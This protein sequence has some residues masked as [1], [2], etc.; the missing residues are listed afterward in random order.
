MRR[1]S[2]EA[3]V[4]IAVVSWN[5]RRLL[6]RCLVSM[7]PDAE[8]G[9]ADVWVV[10]NGSTD[11]SAEMVEESFQWVTLVRAPE[12][13]GYGR[14]VNLV[15]ERTSSA[16]VAPANA[17]IELQPGSLERLLETGEAT[18]RAG[19]IA[20]RLILPDGSTQASVQP[21]PSIRASLRAA[22]RGGSATARASA[23]AERTGRASRVD[24]ATGAFVLVPRA[25]W[26]AVG[27][28]DARQW[29]Y[30]EDLDLAWRL[31]RAGCA[32]WY[33][34]EARVVH[35]L[36]VA[37]ARAFGDEDSRAIRWMAANYRWLGRRRGAL[38]PVA[39]GAVQLA[40]GTLRFARGSLGAAIG[41]PGARDRRERARRGLARQVR[42]Q[43][44]A[45]TEERSG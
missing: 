26:E 17:D 1:D 22:G 12:N 41:R 24:W 20:P 33:D 10:D 35:H 16:W 14:A 18:P 13:L 23:E 43:R 38:Y 19:C 39:Y 2:P 32:S 34:P 8:R 4:A 7:R 45:R 21:F 42:A 37:A 25:A 27:G 40:L 3:P 9:L 15:A 5:T 29:M 6:E 31:A 30:A 44:M 36:S 28:F 11:G